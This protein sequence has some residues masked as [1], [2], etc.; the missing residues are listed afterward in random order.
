VCRIAR[1]ASNVVDGVQF[2]DW[3]LSTFSILDFGFSIAEMPRSLAERPPNP[4]SK[5]DN[6]KSVQLSSE[7]EGCARNPAKVEDLVQLQA[8]A[9]EIF[10]FRFSIF[11]WSES[12][13][14][15]LPSLQSKIQNRKSKIL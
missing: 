3:A 8:R 6:P 4:Q 14:G 13:H 9:L 12:L 5:I 2:L 1:D 11:D 10:D 7:C 15:S